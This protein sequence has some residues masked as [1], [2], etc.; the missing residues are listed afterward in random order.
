M[1]KIGL[2]LNP[3]FSKPMQE[4]EEPYNPKDLYETL[5]SDRLL[6]PLIDEHPVGHKK[7]SLF[8]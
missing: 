1:A 5:T 7:R 6:K 2:E 8:E 4:H 3:E